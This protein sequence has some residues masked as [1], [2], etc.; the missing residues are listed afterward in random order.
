MM[1]LKH[2]NQD[3]EEG[4]AGQDNGEAKMESFMI[5]INWRVTIIF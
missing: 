2:S 1:Y 3:S 4:F 5:G